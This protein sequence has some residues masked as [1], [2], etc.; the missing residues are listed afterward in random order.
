MTRQQQ[1]GSAP[2]RVHTGVRAD[3]AAID[4]STES[5]GVA[6]PGNTRGERRQ[7]RGNP[8]KLHTRTTDITGR[9][10]SPVRSRR[11]RSVGTGVHQPSREGDPRCGRRVDG[12]RIG[13]NRTVGVLRARR[14]PPFPDL[15]SHSLRLVS[16]GRVPERQHSRTGTKRRFSV[17]RRSHRRTRKERRKDGNYDIERT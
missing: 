14:G 8:D 11:G 5:L 15:S 9:R 7:G 13:A 17:R 16:P 4:S 12:G 3:A 6:R 2:T 10:G 1:F